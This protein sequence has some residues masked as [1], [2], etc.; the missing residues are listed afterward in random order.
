MTNE[1]LVCSTSGLIH[2]DCWCNYCE[3]RARKDAYQWR[4][5]NN[6]NCK[7]NNMYNDCDE[8]NVEKNK[9]D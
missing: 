2:D 8:C 6:M 1:V 9:N 3:D 4:V 7:H 5:E